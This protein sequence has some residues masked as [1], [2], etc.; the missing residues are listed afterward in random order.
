MKFG[1]GVLVFSIVLGILYGVVFKS[2]Y[3]LVPI[4]AGIAS[5]FAISGL[6]TALLGTGLWRVYTKK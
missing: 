6:A 1:V 4:D 5:L 3:P 2:F